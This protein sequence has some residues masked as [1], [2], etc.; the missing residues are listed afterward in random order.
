M[1][2]HYLQHA[3]FEQPGYIE[4]WLLENH[5]SISSTQ[6]FERDYHLPEIE[7]IDAV[8][9]LGGPMGV[10]DEFQFPWLA[11]EKEFLKNCINSGKKVLGVCL[12][13]QLIA[14]CMGAKIIPAKNKEVGW[15]KVR[16]TA[17]CKKA[18]WLFDLFKENPTVFHWHGDQFEI[19]QNGCWNGLVSEANDNQLLF[20]NEN[21]IGLQIHLEVTG[22]TMNLML[23]NSTH[24]L[25]AGTF[26]QSE[27]EIKA[28][29]IH[30]QNCNKI[31]S[32]I[33]SR[34]LSEK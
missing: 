17:D 7:T 23:K 32:Q 13:A 20:R 10:Y 8:I 9:F 5:H 18:D 28:G 25:Q 16:P 3:P 31:L 26:I 15:Y 14:D 22:K 4:T 21:I 34:W 12:G 19:P 30:I 6:F 2:V 27:N 29:S 33:L 11:A 24:D 1:K